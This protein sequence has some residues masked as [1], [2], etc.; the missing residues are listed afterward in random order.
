MWAGF[1]EVEIEYL[2]KKGMVVIKVSCRDLLVLVVWKGDGVIIVVV[3]MIIVD[4][5]GICVF[6]IGG[7]GGVYWGVERMMD[8]FVDL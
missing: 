5:V 1:F 2:G 7:I 8:I 4:L 3:I 6:V